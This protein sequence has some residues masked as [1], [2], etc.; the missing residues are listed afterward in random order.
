MNQIAP[1]SMRD[2]IYVIEA[3]MKKLP[4]IEIPVRHYFIP[5]V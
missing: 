4:Q 1:L 3:E 2:K 5:G